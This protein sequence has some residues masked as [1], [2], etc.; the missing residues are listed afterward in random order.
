MQVLAS[1]FRSVAFFVC[2]FTAHVQ[3][4]QQNLKVSK[5]LFAPPAIYAQFH[6]AFINMKQKAASQSLCFTSFLALSEFKKCCCCAAFIKQDKTCRRFQS[7]QDPG[8]LLHSPTDS[9]QSVA[10]PSLNLVVAY[11]RPYVLDELGMNQ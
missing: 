7:L 10:T 4:K 9:Q 2:L 8:R 1:C 3:R 11:R 6:S 5:L